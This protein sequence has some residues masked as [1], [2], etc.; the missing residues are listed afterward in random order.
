MATGR[1]DDAREL[2][3][4][5]RRWCRSA[6]SAFAEMVL[7][8]QSAWMALS[9]GD[10]EGA[11]QSVRRL[12]ES[13]ATAAD[14]PDVPHNLGTA[15]LVRAQAGDRSATRLGEEAVAVARRFP[16]P[17]LLVMALARAAEVAVL[18]GT[19]GDARHHVVELVDTLRR[20]GARSWVAEAYELAAIVFGNDQ[21]ETAAIALGAADR[22][23]TALGEPAG[24]AFL[25]GPALEAAGEHVVSAL[26]P[27]EF[28]AQ[29]AT[30]A[31][32][33]I[34][35]ALSLVATR[36]RNCT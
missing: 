27:D 17:Q 36:L 32:L 20:L 13:L 5:A 28:A 26:G 4:Q 6:G 9:A 16:V 10:V 30:G 14:T 29:K 33:P 23:R 24:P 21:P 12:L 11:Q 2:L 31:G 18:L 3:G 25:L 19:P 35:E 34:D 8:R 22:L 1:L 15:A 7:D